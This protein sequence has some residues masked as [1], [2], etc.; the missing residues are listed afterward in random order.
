MWVQH[1]LNRLLRRDI[2]TALMGERG[3]RR[4]GETDRNHREYR[5]FT[6]HC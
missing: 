4:A 2:G 5:Q 1:R 3:D 6:T